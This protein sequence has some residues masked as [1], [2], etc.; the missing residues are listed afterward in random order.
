MSAT[1]Y[2]GDN[3]AIIKSKLEAKSVDLIYFNPPF[4]TTEHDW[5]EALDWKELF[6]EFYRVL[7]DTGAIVIHCSVPFNYTLIRSAPKP[8]TYSWYWEKENNTN[9]LL[10][11][12]QPLRT[13]EEIL[14]WTHKKSRYFSQRVGDEER[15]FTPGGGNGSGYYKSA[16]RLNR[17]KVKGKVQ[18]HIIKMKRCRDGFSTRPKELIEL[19]LKSYTLE[20]D[21]VLDPTCYKGLC[22]VVAKDLKRKWIG[23]DKYFLPSLLM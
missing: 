20:G 14:V 23:I 19:I 2:Q 3:L 1:Y 22:G 18:T 5:D 8:P 7:K 15:E 11:K 10:S 4:A 13:V 21:V 16:K 12:Y 9:P 6:K 17:V